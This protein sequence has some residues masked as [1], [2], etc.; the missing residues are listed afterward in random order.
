MDVDEDV[1]VDVDAGRER[2]HSVSPPGRKEST[3]QLRQKT[4]GQLHRDGAL[5]TLKLNNY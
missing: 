4:G 5:N 1:V 3:K 2:A